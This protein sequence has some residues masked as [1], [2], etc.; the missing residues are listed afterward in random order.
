MS[1]LF[2]RIRAGSSLLSATGW[3]HLAGAVIFILC[4]A[5]DSTEVYGINVWAKPVKFCVSIAIYVWT[6]ALLLGPLEDWWARKWLA[7]GI[8]LTMFAEI[9]LIALQSARGV[10]SHFNNKTAFDA[11]VFGLMGLMI[12][13]NTILVFGLFLGYVWRQLALDPLLVAGVRTGLILFMMGSL[14]GVIMVVLQGHTIGAGDGGPGLPLLNWSTLHGD[15]RIA[16]AVGLHALQVIPLAAWWISTRMRGSSRIAQSLTL[17][18][19]SLAYL[20]ALLFTLRLAF[21]GK[22]L[23]GM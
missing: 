11:A 14:V 6:I 7:R 21:S 23:V 15:L 3:A 22:P 16:H 8:A 12:L 9:T 5:F 10:P 18:T 20:G 4:G 17:M 19:I 13:I 1:E 2:A